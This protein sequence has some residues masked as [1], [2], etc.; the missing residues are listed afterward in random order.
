MQRLDRNVIC[1][2]SDQEDV[3]A[4]LQDLMAGD[5]AGLA[6]GNPRYAVLLT[7]Q[8]KFLADGI[9]SMRDDTVYWDVHASQADMLLKKLKLYRLRKQIE[10]ES[11]G[12]AVMWHSTPECEYCVQDPRDK[13]LG[14]RMIRHSD[15]AVNEAE[16]HRTRIAAAIAEGVY[17]LQPEKDFPL[18]FRLDEYDGISFTKGC[19]VGQEVT[20][21]SKHRGNIRKLTYAVQ[22]EGLEP[23]DIIYSELK[24]FLHEETPD[25]V[26]HMHIE[27][28]EAGQ[29]CSVSGNTAIAL[30]EKDIA[31]S[32]TALQT[33][34]YV[35]LTLT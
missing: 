22:A 15:D 6:P 29:I 27:G 19:Y 32:G 31:E 4:F 35:I 26:R 23:G 7:P 13:R 28:K 34:S 5:I 16:Y 17:D 3:I 18:P 20:T 25:H 24:H 14:W 1:L 12:D 11:T 8:G 33:E 21:R 10:I 30:L 9:L 2:K